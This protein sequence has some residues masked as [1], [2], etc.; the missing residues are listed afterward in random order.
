MAPLS[1]TERS[2]RRRNKLRENPQVYEKYKTEQSKKKKDDGS[3]AHLEAS[4]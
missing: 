4:E 1:N 3:K 2:R